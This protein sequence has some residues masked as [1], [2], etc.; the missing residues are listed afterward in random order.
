M[1]SKEI[2][3]ISTDIEGEM[4]IPP[5]VIE[6]MREHHPGLDLSDPDDVWDAVH[7]VIHDRDEDE[8][9]DKEIAEFIV[10]YYT[11]NIPSE[12]GYAITEEAEIIHGDTKFVVIAFGW[13]TEMEH[14]H[15]MYHVIYKEPVKPDAET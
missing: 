1:K 10:N 6:K 8:V 4:E 9:I 12:G 3:K 13:T 5:K 2:G 11:R 7:S 14:D 15:C